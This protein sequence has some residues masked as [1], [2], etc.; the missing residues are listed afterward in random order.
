[1]HVGQQALGKLPLQGNEGV[2]RHVLPGHAFGAFQRMALREDQGKGHLE[3]FARLQLRQR[4]ALG[5]DADVRFAREHARNHVVDFAVGDAYLD[6]GLAGAV[7][8]D[9]FGQQGAA[10][11]LRRGD[12]DDAFPELRMVCHVRQRT[13]EIVDH[14]AK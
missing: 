5:A 8:G 11:Q 3:Q 9:G 14:L 7:G 1:M 4:F 6:V 13:V 12:A 10:H 2:A